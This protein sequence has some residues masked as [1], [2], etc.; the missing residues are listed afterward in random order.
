MQGIGGYVVN[1]AQRCSTHTCLACDAELAFAE[2]DVVVKLLQRCI[3]Q[4]KVICCTREL[5]YAYFP[6]L[7]LQ[8]VLKMYISVLPM[9]GLCC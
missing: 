4:W 6:I 9:I 7:S 8:H 5:A 1:T 2:R 3:V